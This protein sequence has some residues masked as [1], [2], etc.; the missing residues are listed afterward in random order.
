M[1]VYKRGQVL[2]VPFPFTDLTS[3]NQRPALVI[4]SDKSNALRQDVIVLAITSQTP[5]QLS[6]D[7]MIVPA[8]ELPIWGLPKPSIIKLAKIFTIHQG[9]IR[10]AFGKVPDVTLEIILRRVQTQFEF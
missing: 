10:R 3:V 4:S 2:L 5:V 7:E 1:T 8:P 9:L 6:P